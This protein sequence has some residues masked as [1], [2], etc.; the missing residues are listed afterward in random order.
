MMKSSMSKEYDFA[1]TDDY[2]LLSVG[3]VGVKI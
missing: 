3:L 1:K 2:A